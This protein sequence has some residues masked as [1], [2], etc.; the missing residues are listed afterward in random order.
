MSSS[1][2]FSVNQTFNFFFD[3]I[4]LLKSNQIEVYECSNYL[5]CKSQMFQ[6]KLGLGSSSNLVHWSFRRRGD[7][8]WP[9]MSEMINSGYIVLPSFWISVSKFRIF[10][11]FIVFVAVVL[12]VIIKMKV[13]HRW[14]RALTIEHGKHGRVCSDIAST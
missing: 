10:F 3:Y 14:D 7:S 2:T 12:L 4:L 1:I 5:I 8:K 9:Q 13:V 6:N 11:D